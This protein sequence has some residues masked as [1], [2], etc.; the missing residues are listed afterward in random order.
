MLPDAQLLTIST[1]FA[2]YNLGGL[3]LTAKSLL[4][5]SLPFTQTDTTSTKAEE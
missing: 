4:D 2:N 3:S 5:P 1:S